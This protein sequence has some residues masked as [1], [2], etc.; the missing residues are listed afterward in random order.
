M[1]SYL[2]NPLVRL[3]HECVFQSYMLSVTKVQVA[4][5]DPQRKLHQALQ[6]AA[7][8]AYT[9]GHKGAPALLQGENTHRGWRHPQVYHRFTTGAAGMMCLQLSAR[10]T[11]Q[12]GM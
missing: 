11:L 9:S 7:V 10:Y 4:V 5:V 12:P 3:L 8:K 2:L 1:G 6:K